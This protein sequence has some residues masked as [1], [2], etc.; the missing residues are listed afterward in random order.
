MFTNIQQTGLAK[1]R[2]L[3][4]A[5]WAT[6]SVG[7][8]ACE[9]YADIASPQVYDSSNIR[10]SYPDNW[11]V[12]EDASKQGFRYIFIESPGDAIFIIQIYDN[13]IAIGLGDFASN[14]S[15]AANDETAYVNVSDSIFEDIQKTG[16][17]MAIRERFSLSLA[18][19]T[20]PHI[21]DY[22]IDEHGSHIVYFIGQVSTECL[23]MVAP[24]F[25]LILSSFRV[26]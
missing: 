15:A 10:F 22:Y 21:R 19:E 11:Q 18:G 24:G 9:Q 23:D 8:T 4:F 13:D 3:A 12:T 16:F 26:A 6:L 1:I 17:P 25:D 14:F 20:V 7:L 2:V 5:I